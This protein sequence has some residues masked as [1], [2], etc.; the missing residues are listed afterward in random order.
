[1][2]EEIFNLLKLLIQTKTENPPGS[3]D[4]LTDHILEWLS[5]WDPQYKKIW[6]ESGRSCLLLQLEGEREEYIGF[7]GH[8]DTVPAGN[9]ET[10]SYDPF[11]A[12]RIGTAVYGRGA[13]DMKGGIAAMLFLYRYYRE[14]QKKPPYG[15]LFLFTADE[16]AQG[17]GIQALCKQK[18]VQQMKAMFVCEPTGNKLGIGEMGTLW[19]K[20]SIKGKGCHAAMSHLGV[21]ALEEGIYLIEKFKKERMKT[22]KTHPMLGEESCSLTKISAGVKINIIPENAE[23]FLDIRTVPQ[24]GKIDQRHDK[25][26]K[27]AETVCKDQMKEKEGL[28]ASV[29]VL[30]NRPA[31]EMKPESAFVKNLQQLGKEANR[32]LKVCAVRFFT[33][34]SIVLGKMEIPFV[35]FGPGNPEECHKAD[36]KNDLIQIEEAIELYKIFIEG[37]RKTRAF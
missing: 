27:L 30:T 28:T 18:E 37:M 6:L 11:E 36:E 31:I 21:N 25:I 5:P 33:D 3:E 14:Q 15:I 22:C 16:E 19:L 24:E 26:V 20:F 23:I 13:A 34:A 29:T 4:A 10:W 32:N 7:V 35:I 9:K 2:Q 1:M 12:K 8:L 17:K